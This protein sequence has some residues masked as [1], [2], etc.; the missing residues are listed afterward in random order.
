MGPS[1]TSGTWAWSDGSLEGIEA[2]IRKGVAKPKN[3]RGVMPPMG[4][5]NLSQ[6]EL[7][8]VAVYVWSLGHTAAKPV[9]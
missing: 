5:S 3:H 8:A 9:Q 4:G 2:T 7:D 6:P 1:L